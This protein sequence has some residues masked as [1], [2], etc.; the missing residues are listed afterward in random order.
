MSVSITQDSETTAPSLGLV[1][2][3]IRIFLFI[4]MNKHLLVI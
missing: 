1:S 2:T 4:C 3:K